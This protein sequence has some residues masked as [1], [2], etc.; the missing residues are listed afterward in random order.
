MFWSFWSRSLNFLD[1]EDFGVKIIFRSSAQAYFRHR[2]ELWWYFLDN[3][4]VPFFTV[5]YTKHPP[6]LSAI[7]WARNDRKSVWSFDF[8]FYRLTKIIKDIFSKIITSSNQIFQE[9]R[10]R[11]FR[12]R[13]T[14]ISRCE[15]EEENI[16]EIVFFQC[17]FKMK[18][19]FFVVLLSLLLVIETAYCA[20][21]YGNSIGGQYNYGE[22]GSRGFQSS[23]GKGIFDFLFGPYPRRP[24][25]NQRP[26]YNRPAQDFV[27]DKVPDYDLY[28]LG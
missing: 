27:H 17:C 26:S 5:V 24:Y 12:E 4:R 28:L 21:D 18:L 11:N 3:S 25:N 6:R 23:F 2:L 19:T 8:R 15:E 13:K 9:W 16:F 10:S 7:V 14:H 1:T 22:S 20:P